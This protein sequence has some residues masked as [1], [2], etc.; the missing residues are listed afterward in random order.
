MA[1]RPRKPAMRNTISVRPARMAILPPEI[2]IT[3][4][5]PASWSRRST[6]SSRPVRSPITIAVT[7]PAARTLQRPTAAPAGLDVERHSAA[8]GRRGVGPKHANNDHRRAVVFGQATAGTFDFAPFVVR[9]RLERDTKRRAPR[10]M[11]AMDREQYAATG[12][13]E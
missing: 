8:A 12:E 1:V 11:P 2:A 10:R 6:E 3:W 4:Y 13:A 9:N 7:M 5:V